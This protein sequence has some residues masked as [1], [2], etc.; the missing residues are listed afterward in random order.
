[1][2]GSKQVKLKLNGGIAPLPFSMPAMIMLC[3]YLATNILVYI[4]GMSYSLSTITLYGFLGA[5][6]FSVLVSGRVRLYPHTIWCTAFVVLCGISCL[7]AASTSRAI[8]AVINMTKVLIFAFM[9]CNLVITQKQRELAMAI[10]SLAAAVMFVYLAA[11]G[12]LDLEEG[13][14]LG[15]ALT[16]NANLFATLFM[17]AA[18]SSVYFI[19]FSTNKL[20]KFAYFVFFIMQLIALSLSGGRKFFLMPIALFSGVQIMRTDKKGRVRMLRNFLPVAV[21]LVILWWAM[22]N[23]EF[24]YD[25]IGYRMEG[26]LAAF[27]GEGEVDYSTKERQAMVEAGIALWKESPLLGHGINS[28]SALTHW[29]V[30]SHNNYVELLCSLGLIGLG[31]YYAY[32]IYILV[33]L[34][35]S[36]LPTLQKSYWCLVMIGFLVYDI[37]AVS[38]DSFPQHMMLVF[39]M[40]EAL[41]LPNGQIADDNRKVD[42][43]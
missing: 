13:E 21:A 31:I 18:V 43:S 29:G 26:L 38:Y 16:G 34:V 32:Y 35:R 22:F 42:V 30:Y 17:I 8:T 12:H 10:Y 37:G 23:V 36:K 24:L 15:A 9:L 4:E 41:R 27:T 7:Y 19:F 5:T 11:T 14:R 1:M 40:K 6:A 25:A 39:A 20:L 3:A 28:F 2:D 33:K